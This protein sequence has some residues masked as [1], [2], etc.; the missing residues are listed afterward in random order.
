MSV[1]ENFK[2]FRSN[3]LIAGATIGTI[4]YRYKRITRQLNTDFWS[5][6]SEVNHSLYVGSYGRDTA[7]RGVSDLD[8][9]FTLPS[10]IYH[11]YNSYIGNGQ[12]SLLQAVKNSISKTYPTSFVAGDGQVVAIN[13]DDGIRFEILPCFLNQDGKSFTYP[14]SNGGGSWKT[15]NPRAEIEAIQIRN[16]VTAN[17]NLKAI[18]RMTRIW[19]DRH[20]VPIGGLL[21]D[22]LAYQWIETWEHRDKSF[23]YHDYLVRDFMLHLATRDR[24]QNYWQAPGSNQYVWK[25]GNF[26]TPAKTAYDTA[27]SAISHEAGDR[28]YTARN[29]WREIFGSVYP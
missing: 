7:A 23:L 17:K 26:Q 12:S 22:T 18:C 11:Q 2:A 21:I 16:D 19:R 4:S 13:F 3:Y 25:K 1:S 28:P 20:S 24:S 6:N 10:S 15:T 27:V 9:A 8:V 29:K 5:S 14:D